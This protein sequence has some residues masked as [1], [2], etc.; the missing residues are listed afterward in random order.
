MNTK[1]DGPSKKIKF[2]KKNAHSGIA[3]SACN[4]LPLRHFFYQFLLT[5]CLILNQ[6]LVWP[7]FF[8]AICGWR[9]FFLPKLFFNIFVPKIFFDKMI[10]GPKKIL[11]HFFYQMTKYLLCF[12]LIV[13]L[14][15]LLYVPCYYFCIV[16]FWNIL[17]SKSKSIVFQNGCIFS[18]HQ[19]Q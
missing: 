9:F 4:I 17:K 12:M 14:L 10:F 5:N 13:I 18:T 15:L 19:L 1:Q 7:I 2:I 8:V 16:W 6:N 11:K 3:Y